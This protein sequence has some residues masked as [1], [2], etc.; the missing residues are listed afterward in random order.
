MKGW[1]ASGPHFMIRLAGSVDK[2]PINLLK[3]VEPQNGALL[4]WGPFNSVGAALDLSRHLVRQVLCHDD[5]LCFVPS[6][7]PS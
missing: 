2:S 5:L 6:R 4:F 3:K 1:L 7:V